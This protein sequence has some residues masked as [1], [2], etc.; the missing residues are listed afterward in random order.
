MTLPD[1]K[2]AA[3]EIAGADM[4]V[5]SYR[6]VWGFF[7]SS[8]RELQA[9]FI[10][11]DNVS[12]NAPA[13]FWTKARKAVSQSTQPAK[14]CLQMLFLAK[15]FSIRIPLFSQSAVRHLSPPLTE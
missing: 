13:S 8:D 11:K 12:Q 5:V 10:T 15:P 7:G 6:N 14:A 9:V 1:A 3:R 4:H 2:K